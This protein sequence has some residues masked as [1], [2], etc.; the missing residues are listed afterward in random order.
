MSLSEFARRLEASFR[1]SQG[2]LNKLHA[3]LLERRTSWISVRP[4]A[5][6]PSADL[7]AIGVELRTED[8]VRKELLEELQTLLPLPPGISAA[9]AH[10][11]V[12]R[13]AEAIPAAAARTLRAASDEVTAIA[14]KVRRELA[15]GKRLLGFAQRAQE[16]LM[17]DLHPGD[18][19]NPHAYDRN[20]RRS[21]GL[22]AA[23][24]AGHLVDG[25]M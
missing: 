4:G 17:A 2:L 22:S 23:T 14:E 3:G 1:N 19:G 5:L 10:V 7:E 18:T 25:R 13:I 16:G 12:S 9:A 15:F 8:D 24:R 21:R 20:A 6:A 11:N